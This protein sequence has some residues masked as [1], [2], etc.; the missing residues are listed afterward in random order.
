MALM[1]RNLDDRTFQDIVDEAKKRIAASCPA[2]TDHN[3]SDPGITLV[4]LFAW[5]T[6]MILYRLNQVPEK[7]YIKFMELLGL[8]LRESE[9]AR[10]EVTFYLTAPQPR[11][12]IIPSG[13]EVATLR[14]ETNPSINF[15][16]D[17]D[18]AI[19]PPILGNLFTR[20]I[21]EG[22]EEA[23]DR[24]HILQQLGVAPFTFLAF[25]K[26]VRVGNALYIG[27]D[28]DLSHH[29]LAIEITCPTATSRG[30]DPDNPP[31][32]WE[33]WH[34][35]EGE[36]RWQ[37]VVVEEDGSGGMSYS[38]RIVLR[39][40]RLALHEF[41]GKRGYW[42]RCRVTEAKSGRNYD[43]SPILSN[44]VV[45]S[46][47]GSVWA[48][49][50]SVVTAEALGRTDG[51]PGQTFKVEN[52]P[53]LRRLKGE[54]VEIL[55]PG[56]TDWEPWIEVP[57]FADSGPF[58]KHFTCDSATGEV[59]FGP[60]IRHPD[61]TSR[62]YGAIP[63]RG[64]LVRFSTYRY[65]GGVSGNV[66]AK[67][68]TVLKT[69]IPYVD[70]VVNHIDA[71]GGIDPETI[72]MAQLRAPQLLRSRGRAVTASD[73]E[74]LAR[75]GDSRVQRARCIQTPTA[76]QVYVLIVPRVNRP[77]G[78]I[79]REQLKLDDDLRGSVRRYLDEY[80]LLTVQLDVRE[81]EYAWV[82]VEMSVVASPDADQERV[83][84]D[85]QARLYRFL[86]PVVGGQVGEGWPFGRDLYP[87]YIYA[88]LQNVRGIEYVE[89][90]HLYQ[91]KV[92]AA[93]WGQGERTEITGRFEVPEHALIASAEHRVSV[94]TIS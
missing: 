90:M 67:A 64:A 1:T 91:V 65:G 94:K 71:T 22:K 69:S 70:R 89:S 57:D 48:T 83:R 59:R 15:S 21:S 58:D 20:E 29:V 81:P 61:G 68:L 38:G 14:T 46:W 3:V 16:T 56:Q 42:L 84:N 13:T 72:E 34:G 60:A 78:R 8:R 79:F 80:R 6:E 39:L 88:S 41:G 54:A 11:T 10:T 35:G 53:L 19:H 86:N 18:L 2:W 92:P 40:P 25:G 37:P 5:M 66:Q 49:N 87:S 9:A 27:F 77:E 73:Y 30:I 4:E 62:S 31:W 33:G 51:S 26:P 43:E 44:L 50:A 47:G 63:P 52:T 45:T 28:N 17:Q 76:G 74:T 23:K 75:L 12:V 93:D 36:Q 85:V 32:Q 82:A 55:P 24:A 7:N